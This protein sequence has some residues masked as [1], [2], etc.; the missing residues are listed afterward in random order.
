MKPWPVTGAL[1]KAYV[2]SEQSSL[3]KEQTFMWQ[4][5]TITKHKEERVEEEPIAQTPI[6]LM[7][8][9]L[10]I[11]R[12]KYTRN[13]V[14]WQLSESLCTHLT[15]EVAGGNKSDAMVMLRGWCKQ[16]L[17]FLA[18]IWIPLGDISW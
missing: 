2:A 17:G 3:C 15:E 10:E 18:Y 1:W 11:C 8:H 12:D 5:F 7:I 6:S 14:M 9:S 4:P 13:N 16:I